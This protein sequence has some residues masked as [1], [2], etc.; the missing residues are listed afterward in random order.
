MVA[1]QDLARQRLE[2]TAIKTLLRPV[3]KVMK[4]VSKTISESPLY[5]Q[6]SRA[7]PGMPGSGLAPAF[8]SSV[9]T[10]FGYPSGTRSGYVTPNP[11]TPLSAA[12]GPA[13]QATVALTPNT[14]HPPSDFLYHAPPGHHGHR[15]THERVDT[16][17]QQPGNGRR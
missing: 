17:M 4:D 15:M 3:Q 14:V 1:V 6:A 2:L 12:L 11:A 16:V 8:P 13:A 7:G 5:L 9:Q 10:S